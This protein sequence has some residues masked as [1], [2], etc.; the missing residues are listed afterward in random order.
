MY[1]ELIPHSHVHIAGRYG[2]AFQLAAQLQ[3][4]EKALS[5]CRPLSPYKLAEKPAGRDVMVKL[6]QD[7]GTVGDNNETVVRT[8]DRRFDYIE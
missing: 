4:L 3:H 1:H 2:W 7:V 8:R 5:G 6:S